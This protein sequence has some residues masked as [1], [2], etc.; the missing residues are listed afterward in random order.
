M[1]RG[2]PDP[3]DRVRVPS[4]ALQEILAHARA[5]WPDECCGLLLGNGTSI[6]RV[7]RARNVAQSPRRRYVVA[8]ADHFI[9][10]RA[11]RA[12]GL[13]IVGAYHSHPNR[14][15]EPSATDLADAPGTTWLHVIAAADAA[16]VR[17]WRIVNGNFREITLVTSS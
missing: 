16:E 2:R 14:T 8:P 4:A 7:H 5:T 1:P 3:V 9:A 12:D 6:A 10:L 15:A 11:A 17:A 13:E